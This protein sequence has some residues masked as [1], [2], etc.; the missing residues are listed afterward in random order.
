MTASNAEQA[1]SAPTCPRHPGTVA[2]VRCQRCER[3]TCPQCQRPAAVGILC[4]DC[5]QAAQ[6]NHRPLK[7]R[8]GFKAAAGPPRVV[9]TL[10]ALNVAFYLVGMVDPGQWRADWGMVPFLAM[11][12]PWRL[13]TSAFVHAGL[14]HI[15]MNMFVLWQIGS[16]LEPVLGRVRF[17]VIYLLSAIGGSVAVYFLSP[18]VSLTV[19]ASGAVFGVI[20]A[21]LIVL[22]K[23]RLPYQQFALFVGVLLVLGFVIP[24]ISWQGHLGGAVVGALVMLVMFRSVER[25]SDATSAR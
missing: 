2:Y 7:S 23:L 11:E 16:Q 22:R 9:Y 6:A 18:E 4:V 12:E 15:G 19:G 24:V 25:K 1:G 17:V 3:P 5:V 13:V 10:I 8:L 14:F 20:A 21:Y